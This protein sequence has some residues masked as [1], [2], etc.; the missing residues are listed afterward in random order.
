ML[1][2]SLASYRM[3]G[4][5]ALVSERFTPPFDYGDF[6]ADRGAAYR[7]K[8]QSW[9]TL[10]ARDKKSGDWSIVEQTLDR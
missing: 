10:L 3:D 1:R 2:T 9:H 4:M 7:S 8:E 6:P 5:Q